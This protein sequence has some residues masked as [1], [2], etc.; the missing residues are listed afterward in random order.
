[1]ACTGTDRDTVNFQ[2]LQSDSA[3]GQVIILCGLFWFHRESGGVSC[4]KLSSFRT[5]E[6]V[7]F[8]SV[9]G[10]VSCNFYLCVLIVSVPP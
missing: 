3:L 2:P 10:S 1:M 9:P 8:T 6:I 7:F 4:S 5:E